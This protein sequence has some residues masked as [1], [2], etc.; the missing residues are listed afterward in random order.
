M[1]VYLD[2]PGCVADLCSS[3]TRAVI[4]TAF[5]LLT[6]LSFFSV[7]LVAQQTSSPLTSEPSV[8]PAVDGVMYAFQTHRLVGICDW[9][10]LAQQEDFYIHLIRD[11]R[12]AKDVGNVVVEFGGASQQETVDRYTDGQEIPYEQLRRVWNETVGWIPTVTR[13][14]YLNFFAQ[15]R[16]VNQNLKPADRIHVWL[17]NP[18]ID[19]S[20]IQ[21]RDEA[22]Q[23]LHQ[24][25]SYPANLIKTQI[26][27]KDKKAIVIYGSAHFYEASTIKRMVEASFPKAFFMV[28]P[29][30]GFIEKTCSDSFEEANR[31]WPKNTLVS[32]VRGTELQS[33]L[34]APSC[35]F[36]PGFTFAASV[37]QSER[38]KAL[39]DMEDE[40]SGVDGDALLYLG[41]AATLTES[42]T[43]PDLYLDELF[44]DEISRRRILMSGKPLTLSTPLMSPA[45]IHPYGRT[46]PD[47]QK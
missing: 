36:F 45:Y 5:A 19:W 32:P 39:A 7:S 31:R 8:A 24:T 35:H 25:D 26:L 30:V 41:Q 47:T 21:T 14:G 34:Q 37:S 28:T 11:P 18:P 27:E 9:H 16:A 46:G 43:V 13:L 1:E 20:T 15:V 4:R 42:P 33:Q 3:P 2:R 12:F 17:G 6:A 29:Y 38:T 10:G 23:V 40:T 22:I 44:R